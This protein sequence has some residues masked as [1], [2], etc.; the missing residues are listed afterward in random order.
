MSSFPKIKDRTWRENLLDRRHRPRLGGGQ[1]GKDGREGARSRRREETVGRPGRAKW[2]AFFVLSVF[3]LL[4]CG[5]VRV[6]PFAPSSPPLTLRIRAR[7]DGLSRL[8]IQEDTAYWFHLIA[9]AP[10]RWIPAPTFLNEI[11]WNPDWPDVPD[12]NNQ[13][14]LC[15]SSAIHGLPPIA[16]HPPISLE[17]VQARGI[18]TIV[19]QP[20]PR[21][22]FT[23]IVE[24][25]DLTPPD[26]YGDEW[27][28]VI[29]IASP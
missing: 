28:E 8:V 27:Y 14:C 25:D 2:L 12:R 21:N 5:A 3:F 9:S 7:I 13:S 15:S 10:G 29:L 26:T 19:Q 20:S 24:F 4:G 17:I 18:V 11:E 16:Q 23:L 6:V 22:D 1:P